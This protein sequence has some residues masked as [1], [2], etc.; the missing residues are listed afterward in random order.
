VNLKSFDIL[1]YFRTLFL[2]VWNT[3]YSP[4]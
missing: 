2:S 3:P 1:E 4:D